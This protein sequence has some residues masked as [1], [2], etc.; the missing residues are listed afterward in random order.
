MSKSKM[1]KRAQNPVSPLNKEIMK[2]YSNGYQDGAKMQRLAD[3]KEMMNWINSLEEVPGIGAKTA[4][5]IGHYFLENYTH[6]EREQ[7]MWKSTQS[8]S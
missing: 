6:G 8:N 5:K 1:R 7:E 4:L 2:A 3:F